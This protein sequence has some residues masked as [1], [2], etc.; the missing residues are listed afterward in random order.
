MILVHSGADAGVSART[1][2][3]H[4][5]FGRT[6]LLY[7]QTSAVLSVDVLGAC[8]ASWM[9]T[10]N[11]RI[12]WR[13]S[14]GVETDRIDIGHRKKSLCPRNRFGQGF[15]FLFFPFLFPDRLLLTFPLRR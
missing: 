1:R 9:T 6:P 15:H 13:I 5:I 14:I 2:Y 7:S 11:N 12:S 10:N 4:M 3:F 8:P